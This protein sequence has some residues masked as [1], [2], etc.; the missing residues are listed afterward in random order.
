MRKTAG[1]ERGAITH[2]LLDVFPKQLPELSVYCAVRHR[3]FAADQLAGL[4]ED[5][6][7][8]SRNQRSRHRAVTGLAIALERSLN[9]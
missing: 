2:C 7:S 6:Y 9:R 8:T 4:V 1:T 3:V 5:F